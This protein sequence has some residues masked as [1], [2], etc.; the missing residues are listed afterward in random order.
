MS[1]PIDETAVI[2]GPAGSAGRA[3]RRV[4]PTVILVIVCAGI[5]LA[6]LD[7]F[8]VN[9]ALPDIGRGLHDSSL[10]RLSWVINGYTIV[11]AALLIP[12]GR[13]ADRYRQR[14]GFL[15][16]VAVFTVASAACGFAASLP[17]LVAFRLV[18]AAGAALLTPTSLSLVLAAYPA[19]RRA[20]A[21]RSWAAVGGVAAALGPVAGGLLLEAT[22]RAVFFV[23]V[24]IG[25]A[26]IGFGA[27]LLPRVPGHRMALPDPVGVLLIV[28]GVGAL[29]F[30]LVQGGTWGWASAGIIGALAVAAAAIALFVL[31]TLRHRNPVIDPGLFRDRNFSVASVVLMVFS[32]AFGGMLLSIVL[33]EQSAWG[34]SALRTGLAVAPGP[35][36]VPVFSMLVAGRL[37]RR[38]GFPLVAAIGS[39][40]FGGGLIWW[41]VSVTLRPDYAAGVLGGMILSG[42]GVG[43]TLPTLIAAATS[44]LPQKS[45]ASGSG[46][47]NTFRQ[48]GTAIGVA[49]LV[50]V[51]GTP[52]SPVAQLTAYD[53]GWIVLGALALAAAVTA[54]LLHQ[55]SHAAKDRA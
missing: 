35:I 41:S 9:V 15:L 25:L 19:E 11:Y 26:A 30:G 32:G 3:R 43:L 38:L 36:M 42:I 48:I 34:W 50:A 52:R 51:I 14:D 12:A 49:L 54:V 27:W 10:S 24:P 40:L 44:S 23:N 5:I 39:A 6:N 22:W 2:A 45:A 37:I 53:R 18:Q 13:L 46:A 7:L 21:V 16:G 20:G 17:M 1:R 33:W 55:S 29:S 8:V 47:V 28:V 31:H 4:T